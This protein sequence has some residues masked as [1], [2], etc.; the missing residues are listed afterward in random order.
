MMFTPAVSFSRIY[1]HDG[2]C[3]HVM[4][5]VCFNVFPVTESFVDRDG[6]RWDL[7]GTVCAAQA[8]VR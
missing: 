4:C 6:Q 1:D 5:C 2:H 8:G 7:C 3:T